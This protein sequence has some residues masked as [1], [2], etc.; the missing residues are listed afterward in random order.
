MS[1]QLKVKRLT[2]GAKLPTRATPGAA[3]MDIHADATYW[4]DN[5]L[6]YGCEIKPGAGLTFATGL[7]FEIPAGHVLLVYSRSGH[8]FNHQVRL[9]NCT[10]VIDSD[11][12]GELMVRLVN[13]GGS[14]F[15]VR[16][17]D[18]IAQAMLV[19]LP[20]VELIEVDELSETARGAGGLGSTGA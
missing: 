11:Y 13:D 14:A 12:R 20:D 17:G 1:A 9:A 7:A 10:G 16:P 2:P 19:K 8:G 15:R 18:R 3:C 4:N 6:A 5:C